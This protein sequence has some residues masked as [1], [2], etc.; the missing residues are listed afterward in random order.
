MALKLTVPGVPDIYRGA[1]DWEQ[2][3]VDPDNR[4]AVD[5]AGLAQRLAAPQAGRDDKL[6]LTAGLLRLRHRHPEIFLLGQYEPLPSGPGEV[7][8]ARRHGQMRLEVA[9]RIDGTTYAAEAEGLN[10]AGP[11]IA[12]PCRFVI[13]GA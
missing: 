2:S 6:M 13:E 3:Y 12:L 9:V 11:G 8:F 4:R 10:P 5:F 7:R 1:E